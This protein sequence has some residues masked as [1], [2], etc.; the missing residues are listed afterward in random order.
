MPRRKAAD[1]VTNLKRMETISART[2]ER[3]IIVVPSLRPVAAKQIPQRL[4]TLIRNDQA[5]A[6]NEQHMLPVSPR[7]E[8]TSHAQQHEQNRRPT[9][10]QRR[11]LRQP[12]Q[13]FEPRDP[14]IVYKERDR[15][16]DKVVAN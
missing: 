5:D 16:I 4:P 11:R 12:P 10:H 2:D 9:L 6:R 7:T 13:F 15:P 14:M 3:R 1:V 8:R